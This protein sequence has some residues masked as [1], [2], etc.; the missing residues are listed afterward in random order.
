MN[1]CH[2]YVCASVCV[3]YPT[4]RIQR[5][6]AS[7]RFGKF[8]KLSNKINL[9]GWRGEHVTTRRS[10]IIIRREKTVSPWKSI[11]PLKKIELSKFQRH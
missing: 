9:H 1:R 6:T 10:E 4:L 5:L 3:L 8:A 7:R 2:E 11:E